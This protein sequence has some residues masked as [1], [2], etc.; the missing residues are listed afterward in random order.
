MPKHGRITIHLPDNLVVQAKK[1]ALE[2]DTARTEMIANALREALLKERR[3]Q[4]RRKIK[5]T[6]C[7]EGRTFLG[8]DLDDPSS[9]L[10]WMDGIRDSHRCELSRLSTDLTRSSTPGTG[11]GY[12][13][14]SIPKKFA[15]VR[16]W[17]WRKSS[18]S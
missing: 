10:D 5:R 12:K 7:G 11:V 9:V 16:S 17:R 4:P 15:E 2:A 3:K 13:M 1:V 18:R 14:P 6:P 8:V